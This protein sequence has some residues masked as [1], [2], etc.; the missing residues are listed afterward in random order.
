MLSVNHKGSVWEL[1][2]EAA[3]QR[4]GAPQERVANVG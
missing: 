3:A 1:R 2:E 4:T